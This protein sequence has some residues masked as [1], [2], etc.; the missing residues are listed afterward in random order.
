M[1]YLLLPTFYDLNKK[2]QILSFLETKIKDS[3][4]DAEKRWITKNVFYLIVSQFIIN[5]NLQR[6]FYL[7]ELKLLHLREKNSILIQIQNICYK[8]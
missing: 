2:E 6:G 4:K 5:W 8:Y 7:V 1:D 3:E